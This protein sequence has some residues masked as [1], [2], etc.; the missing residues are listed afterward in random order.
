MAACN[1]V[2]LFVLLLVGC[3]VVCGWF[4]RCVLCVLPVSLCFVCSVVVMVVVCLLVALCFV[5]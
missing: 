2:A 5:C 3:C 1:C 4:C